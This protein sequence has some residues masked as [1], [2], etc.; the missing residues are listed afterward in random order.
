MPAD[1]TRML[2]AR[3]C[4]AAH[5]W[6]ADWISAY[7]GAEVCDACARLVWQ[8]CQPA[9]PTND[10]PRKAWCKKPRRHRGACWPF[11]P[12]KDRA[13]DEQGA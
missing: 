8:A 9:P 12:P 3:G 2:K 13:A 11:H 7:N 5:E 4:C 6:A 10:C 1:L